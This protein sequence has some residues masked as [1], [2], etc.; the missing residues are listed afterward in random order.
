MRGGAGSASWALP[1]ALIALSVIPWPTVAK[2][3]ARTRRLDALQ[4]EMKRLQG[5]LSGLALRERGLL[6]DVAR[7]DAEIALRRAELED[8][9]LRLK[10]TE[11]RLESGLRKLKTINAGQTRRAPQLAARVRELYK[12]SAAGTLARLVGPLRDADSLDGIRYATYLSRRDAVQLAE[13]R[14]GA[15]SLTEEQ[16]ILAEE[17][18]RLSA[19]RAQAAQ[20]EAAL[21]AGREARASLLA[22]IRGDREQHQKAL[23]EL[24]EAARSLGRLVE[25]FEGEPSNVTLDVRKFR[26][27]LDWPADGDVSAKFGTVVHPRFKTQVPH[28]GLDI[29]AGQGQPFK[30]IFDGRVAFAA[31]LSGYGL[32]IVVDHGNGVVSVY[33]H[34]EVLLVESGQE[35]VRG[36]DLGRVGDSGSLRGPYLYF[37]L[38]ESGKPVDPSLWLRR[39]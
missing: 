1:I 4:E 27:L 23:G 32:T 13:W 6:G 35:V 22:R 10:D 7:M 29:D 26:G 9:T 2:D 31:A 18:D 30:S 39:R 33:A 25:S 24:E 15:R 36:Q 14:A 38:R 17:R 28:P 34:A 5:E 19:L 37:E 8:V 3:A 11:E 12:R 21:T 20:K 16:A